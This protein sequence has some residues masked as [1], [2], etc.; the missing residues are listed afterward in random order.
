MTSQYFVQLF[1]EDWTDD[2]TVRIMGTPRAVGDVFTSLDEAMIIC[3]SI[4]D[5]FWESQPQLTKEADF[6]RS[7][8]VAAVFRLTNDIGD[9]PVYIRGNMQSTAAPWTSP[10]R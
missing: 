9:A 2:D 8:V 3:D 4:F 5:T 7:G 1:A 6:V 10:Q